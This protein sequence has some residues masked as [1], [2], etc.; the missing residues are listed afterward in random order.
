MELIEKYKIYKS[1]EG[2]TLN[3]LKKAIKDL[4]ESI[5]DPQNRTVVEHLKNRKN[6]LQNA[7]EKI[8]NFE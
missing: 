1:V 6:E 2:Y 5:K 3:A 7:L 4:N 8:E